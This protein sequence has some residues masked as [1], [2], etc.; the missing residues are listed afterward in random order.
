VLGL[1]RGG[2]VTAYYVATELGLPLDVMVARKVVCPFHEEL[3]IG[4]FHCDMSQWPGWR[5]GL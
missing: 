3:T 4:R 1:A 2:V 5:D